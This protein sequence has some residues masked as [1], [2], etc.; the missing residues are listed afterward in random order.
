MGKA[1]QR[2]AKISFDRGRRKGGVSA[3]QSGDLPVED[4]PLD[5]SVKAMF[6]DLKN[7]LAG[8]DAKIDH[9][10]EQMDCI[11]ARVDDHDARFGQLNAR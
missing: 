7:C 9:V 5:T 4:G 10:T 2:Q 8:I 6:L 3:S 1:E 11:K